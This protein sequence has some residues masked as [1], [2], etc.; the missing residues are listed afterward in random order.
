[1]WNL[2]S[3]IIHAVVVHG[4]ILGHERYVR[5]TKTQKIL[6]SC[7]I[8]IS[9]TDKW[10]F[11]AIGNKKKWFCNKFVV[12]AILLSSRKPTHGDISGSSAQMT[13]KIYQIFF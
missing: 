11:L 1:M 2:E 3:A 9:I 8:M 6:F 13:S 10:V 5:T 4:N 7:L 12:C